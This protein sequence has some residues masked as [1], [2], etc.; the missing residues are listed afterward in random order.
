G[1]SG[2]IHPYYVMSALYQIVLSIGEAY[3]APR[4]Y[5]YAA[6]IAQKGEE[7]S[8]GALAYLPF[9]VGKL[10]IGTAGWVLSAFVPEQ[11]Q[12]RPELMWLTFALAASIAPLGLIVFR[13]YIRV[14]EAGRESDL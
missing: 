9:L 10:L 8:Y 7:A 4:D 3:Y 5:E 14:S 12:R 11:G 6:A 1:L 2:A 13:R